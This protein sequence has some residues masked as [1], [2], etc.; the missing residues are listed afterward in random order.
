MVHGCATTF[1]DMIPPSNCS[2]L[3]K[4]PAWLTPQL[5]DRQPF[6]GL[7]LF[8]PPGTFSTTEKNQKYVFNQRSILLPMADTCCEDLLVASLHLALS[9]NPAKTTI[10]FRNQSGGV[11]P[12]IKDGAWRIPVGSLFVCE[13]KEYGLACSAEQTFSKAPRGWKHRRF[14]YC[15]PE[16]PFHPSA[17]LY[18]D[19]NDCP[20]FVE[21]FDP[22]GEVAVA[23]FGLQP[24]TS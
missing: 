13:G 12:S 23:R 22:V 2:M 18:L 5:R 20:C 9:D 21:E 1:H 3:Y 4:H 17:I 6:F 11:R 24:P 7:A 8:L 14:L 16:T 19:N 10:V 15:N